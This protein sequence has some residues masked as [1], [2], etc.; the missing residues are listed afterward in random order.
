ME[1]IIIARNIERALHDLLR[2]RRTG[3]VLSSITW[4]R[5]SDALT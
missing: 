4:R 1:R 3:I 5:T 2:A